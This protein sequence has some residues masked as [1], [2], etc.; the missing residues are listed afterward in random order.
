MGV[1]KLDGPSQCPDLSP[2]K[3]FW[4]ELECSGKKESGQLRFGCKER[5][6]K[7]PILPHK[8][9]KEHPYSNSYSG[10]YHSRNKFSDRHGSHRRRPTQG[11]HGATYARGGHGHELMAG[12]S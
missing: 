4:N 5:P 10:R 6:F 7:K 12:K 11:G 3:Y 2:L 1:Q 8:S 9:E